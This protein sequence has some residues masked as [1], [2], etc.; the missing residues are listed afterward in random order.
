MTKNMKARHRDFLQGLT[1]GRGHSEANLLHRLERRGPLTKLKSRRYEYRFRVVK[2]REAAMALEEGLI[3]LYVQRFG[4][5]PPL[6]SAIPNR[7][8]EP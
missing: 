1:R 6:N 4:E 3:K 8:G 5:A 7:Y 2:D